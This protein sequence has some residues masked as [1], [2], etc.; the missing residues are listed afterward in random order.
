MMNHA[1]SKK[2]PLLLTG[3]AALGALALTLGGAASAQAHVGATPNTNEAG[4]YAVVSVSV[5][6]RLRRFADD[7]GRD[8]DPGRDQRGHADPELVL[9][10]RE[11]DGSVG[12][13]DHRQS[14]Q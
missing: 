11:G 7:E 4:S 14:R 5:P 3:A 8:P 2:R 10:G 6:A 13:P 1:E 9:H 12:Y